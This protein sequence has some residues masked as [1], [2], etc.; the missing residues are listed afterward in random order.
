[1]AELL[2]LLAQLPTHN[3]AVALGQ[4]SLSLSL[5]PVKDRHREA[6]LHHLLAQ[7]VAIGTADRGACARVAQLGVE[8]DALSVGTRYSHRVVGLQL[9]PAY[10]RGMGIVLEGMSEDILVIE[11][12]ERLTLAS[13]GPPPCSP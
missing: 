11:V 8:V 3:L 4:S 1:M 7:Q 13:T 9:P 5:A 10:G 2:C 12:K 6:Y